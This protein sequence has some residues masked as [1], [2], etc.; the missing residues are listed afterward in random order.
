MLYDLIINEEYIVEEGKIYEDM[1]FR[2]LHSEVLIFK[3]VL[4]LARNADAVQLETNP[5]VVKLL[6]AVF[7]PLL[8]LLEKILFEECQYLELNTDLYLR[9]YFGNPKELVQMIGRKMHIIKEESNELYLIC[10]VREQMSLLHNLPQLEAY[11]LQWRRSFAGKHR[12]INR[13]RK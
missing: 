2:F 13:I 7:K 11:E 8:I 5:L 3:R 10:K 6:E 12:L 1:D 9:Y 4:K